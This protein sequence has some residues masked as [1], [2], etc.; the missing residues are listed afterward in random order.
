[1]DML[2]T[3]IGHLFGDASS[4]YIIGF[5]SDAIRGGETSSMAKYHALQYAMFLPIFGLIISIGCYLWATFY[6]VADH[7]RA[8]QEMHDFCVRP[9]GACIFLALSMTEDAIVL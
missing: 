6:I 4:P 9:D 8:K 3:L 7:H 5:I 1:M 2:M